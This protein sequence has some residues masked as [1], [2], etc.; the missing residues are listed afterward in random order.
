[1]KV[2]IRGKRGEKS[3]REVLLPPSERER[4]SD[5]ELHG[6][7][8]LVVTNEIFQTVDTRFFGRISRVELEVLSSSLE[9]NL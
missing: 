3:L 4:E 5:D 9:K 6:K 2:L 8:S 7:H 1:V